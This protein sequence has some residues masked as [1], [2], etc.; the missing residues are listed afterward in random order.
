MVSNKI[1]FTASCAALWLVTG[2][3]GTMI[4]QDLHFITATYV[5]V[6]IVTTIGYG[7]ISVNPEMHWFMIFYVVVGLC[8]AADVFNVGFNYLLEKSQDK[9]C[10][11]MNELQASIRS[12]GKKANRIRDSH[13]ELRDCLSALLIALVFVVGGAIFYVLVEPCSC[14]YGKSHVDGCVA[15]D[16]CAATG[17]YTKDFSQALYMAVITLTTVGFGDFTPRSE[18]GRIFGFFWMI[19]GVLSFGNFVTAFGAWLGAA[20]KKDHSSK[21][22]REIFDS[23]DKDGNGYLTRGEFMSWMLVKE[24]IVSSEQIQHFYDLFDTLAEEGGE[25]TA[26]DLPKLTFSTLQEYIHD[27]CDSDDELSEV[28]Q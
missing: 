1:L 7:D 22:G 10:K 16:T 9:L 4:V 19:A 5:V 28:L 8:V 23:I 15:D 25:T 17:G 12:K 21:F 11:R 6:Q 27:D 18:A 26:D 20:F 2:I 14:S 24:G 3:V 13:H